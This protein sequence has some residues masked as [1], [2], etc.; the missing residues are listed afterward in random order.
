MYASGHLA[1]LWSQCEANGGFDMNATLKTDDRLLI[2]SIVI[3]LIDD[4]ND[5]P[6]VISI[7][8]RDCSYICNSCHPTEKEKELDPS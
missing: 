8:K 1:V 6:I 3:K 2:E 5:I 4:A 7:C